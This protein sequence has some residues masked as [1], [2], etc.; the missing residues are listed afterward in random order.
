MN[1]VVAFIAPAFV[2]APRAVSTVAFSGVV[3][4]ADAGIRMVTYVDG[5]V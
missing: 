3:V 5:Y 1:P 4:L 2:V